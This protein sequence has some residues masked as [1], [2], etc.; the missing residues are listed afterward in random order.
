MEAFSAAGNA[1]SICGLVDILIRAGIE[2]TR[3]YGNARAAFQDIESILNT[4]KTLTE[5][6]ILI[7]TS[8]TEFEHSPYATDDLLQLPPQLP[9]VLQECGSSLDELR[10]IA[11]ASSRKF[12]QSW[13]IQRFKGVQ[14]ATRCKRVQELCVKIEQ[15]K[16][17]LMLLLSLI[18]RYKTSHII[19]H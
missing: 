8:I 4:H 3:L 19:E 7:R 1:F 15:H 13:F 5:V 6:L 11:E 16:A 17:T 9:N 2:S 18:G 10:C 14:W 12:D